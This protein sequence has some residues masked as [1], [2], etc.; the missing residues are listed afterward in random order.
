M[1]LYAFPTPNGQKVSIALEELELSYTFH[2]IDIMKGHQ[3][4][5]AYLRIN[6]NGKIPALVDG[7]ITIFESVA[8]LIYLAEKTGKLL[9]KD[10]KGRYAALQWSLFQAASVG[11]MF[12]QFGHFTVFA[13]EQVP[14]AIERYSK[15]VHRIL[16]VMNQHLTTNT[17]LAGEEYT[18]ADVATWPWLAGYQNFYKQTIDKD[19]YPNVM[20]WYHEIDQRPAVHKG[21]RALKH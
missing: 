17:Y 8:I 18:I 10:P 11:P 15:E 13:K 19:M 12:G 7:E 6:P 4:D 9:P 2:K 16:G 1:D 20:R 14:Y 5:P 21:I 3:H